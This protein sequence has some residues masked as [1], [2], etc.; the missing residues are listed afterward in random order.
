[1]KDFKIRQVRKLLSLS[2]SP[3]GNEAAAALEKAREIAEQY[4]IDIAK[5]QAESGEKYGMIA[6]DPPLFFAGGGY[7]LNFISPLL[8]KHFF[9]LV[10]RSK[11][12]QNSGPMAGTEGDLVWVHGH[13]IHVDIGVYVVEFL[14]NTFRE[15]AAKQEEI[16]EM[17][18]SKEAKD[19]YFIGIIKGLNQKLDAAANRKEAQRKSTDHGRKELGLV[20]LN[21]QNVAEMAKELEKEYKETSDEITPE[22][23]RSF[24]RQIQ[25]Q[26]DGARINIFKPLAG[27]KKQIEGPHG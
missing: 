5:L 23:D 15:L 17:K 12:V 6:S 8:Q 2:N 26:M 18:M 20:L 27:F 11:A 19:S 7:E 24:M 4:G 21:E 1:M 14:V 25:G 16:A 3:N 9:C 22:S 10:T 13:K